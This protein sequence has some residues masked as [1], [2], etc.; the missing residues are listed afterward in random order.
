MKYLPFKTI[1]K[2]TLRKI[3]N[4]FMPVSYTHLR[5]QES[6]GLGDVY[7]RQDYMQTNLLNTQLLFSTKYRTLHLN[8]M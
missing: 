1:Q 8:K 7:K 6:R 5:A 4:L 3:G 2:R